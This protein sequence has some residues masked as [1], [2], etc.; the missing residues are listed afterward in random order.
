MEASERV[1]V[2]TELEG[3]HTPPPAKP[4]QA[5]PETDTMELPRGARP[6]TGGRQ[7]D[8]HE[9]DSPQN[10][11]QDPAVK[12]LLVLT[13]TIEERYS[14]LAHHGRSVAG[15]CALTARELGLDPESVERIA[16]AGELHD[17]G[18]VGVA[19][20][21]LRKPEPLSSD[22]WRQVMRHPQIGADLLVSSNLDDIAQ[23]VLAHH[24][25]PDASGYPYGVDG[26]AIPLES[27]ILAV[28]DAYDAMRTDRVYKLG[29]TH[30]ES[31]E[32]LRKCAGTQFDPD[33]V[34][35]FLRALDRIAAGK[36]E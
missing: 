22:E 4:A 2:D 23:W 13:Q 27:R 25:R 20:E 34:E 19:D 28:A 8:T 12:P 24:E 31:A 33:V 14:D 18:K 21:I 6:D 17:V 30:E 11:R 1:K 10:D 29:R 35:A 36:T 7:T 5:Q 9:V 32:E 16:L 26:E 15:Y 3:V